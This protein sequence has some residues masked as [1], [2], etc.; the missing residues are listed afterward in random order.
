VLKNSIFIIESMM[1]FISDIKLRDKTRLDFIG[2]LPP[3]ISCTTAQQQV[4]T[5]ET[6]M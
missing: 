5:I 2:R 3:L 4:N 6:C 1:L